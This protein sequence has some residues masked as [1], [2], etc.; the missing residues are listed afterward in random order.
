MNDP[1]F[2]TGSPNVLP[3]CSK[4]SLFEFTSSYM[5]KDMISQGNIPNWNVKNHFVPDIM[6]TQS[7]SPSF[8]DK[9]APIITTSNLSSSSTNGTSGRRSIRSNPIISSPLAIGPS[10]S[11]TLKPAISPNLKPRL[12]G[13]SP[14]EVAEQLANKS[15]YHSIM[16]GTAESLG[17]LYP[18]GVNSILTRRLTCRVAEQKRRD[19]LKQSFDELKKILPM[20]SYDDGKNPDDVTSIKNVSKLFLLK[21]DKRK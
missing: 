11:H 8:S 19:S 20:P 10:I 13:V 17:I 21:R 7:S 9:L 1:N 18:S 6:T 2:M 14:D 5:N 3:N 4:F 15:N 16:E 12:P